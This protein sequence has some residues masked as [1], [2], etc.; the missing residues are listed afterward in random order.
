MEIKLSFV[1]I[2]NRVFVKSRKSLVKK[3]NKNA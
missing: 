1:R 2:V 3:D